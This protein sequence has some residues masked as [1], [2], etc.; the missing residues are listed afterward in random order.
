MCNVQL[1]RPKSLKKE[2][3]R[4]QGDR[5]SNLLAPIFI[6]IYKV[7]ARFGIAPGTGCR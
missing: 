1:F 3:E 5:G 2:R 7:T 6:L 4:D